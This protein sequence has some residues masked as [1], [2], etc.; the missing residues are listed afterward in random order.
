MVNLFKY[1]DYKNYVKERLK[2]YPRNGH[3]QLRKI[4]EY[5]GVNSVQMS[6]VFNGDRDLNTEQALELTTYFKLSPLE[7]EYFVLLVQI[8]R[9]G[10]H[11]LKTHYK[12]QL[13]EKRKEGLSSR[14][15]IQ[16][17]KE[18]TEAVKAE[19]YS[20]WIN[21]ATRLCLLLN[22]IQEAKSVAKHLNVPLSLIE[23]TIEFLIEYGFCKVEDGEI[24][25]VDQILYLAPNSPLVAQQHINW[26]LKGIEKV[27]SLR[28]DELFFS[29]QM[30]LATSDILMIQEELRALI[31]N[32]TTKIKNSQDEELAC[33]NI[34][35]FRI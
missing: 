21:S 25:V 8:E 19:Y 26:R 7:T 17:A 16:G 24:K 14:Q 15:R 11:K 1:D 3:G 20:S 13:L 32:V 31:A 34:D 22:H 27:R 35:W 9:A 33:L 10:T 2:T 23:K 6:H 12:K 5:L 29:G 30:T 28:E 4:S 18:I